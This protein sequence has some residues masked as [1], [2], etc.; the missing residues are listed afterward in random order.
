MQSMIN[1]QQQQAV[2]QFQNLNKEQ[3]AER[4]ASE[5]NKLGISKEQLANIIN[6]LK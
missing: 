2:N 1:P 4:I 6:G 3:Q 5:C